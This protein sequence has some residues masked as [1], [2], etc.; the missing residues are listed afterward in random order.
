M[1]EELTNEEMIEVDG[2]I[3]WCWLVGGIIA[4]VATVGTIAVGVATAGIG[5]PA[6]IGIAADV[7]SI[8]MGTASGVGFYG[9]ANDWE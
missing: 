7:F 4:A 5:A 1:F 6:A 3:S 8:I 2:G 9:A